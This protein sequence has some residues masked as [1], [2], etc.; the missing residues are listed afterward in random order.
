MAETQRVPIGTE[1]IKLDAFLKFAGVCA[2]GGEGKLLVA[3][4]AVLVNGE[5]CTQRGR[6]LREGDLVQLDG[7]SYLVERHAG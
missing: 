3:R 6:K 7:R 4:G 1:Y 5:P 2:T